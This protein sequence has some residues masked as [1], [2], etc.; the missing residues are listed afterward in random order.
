M[1]TV[2]TT[3][4]LPVERLRSIEPI[5]R[6]WDEL[7]DRTGASPFLRPGWFAAWLSA[8]G[9]GQQPV[10][11][12]VRRD[13]RLEAVLPLLVGRRVRCPTNS[14]TP[15]FDLV[16]G[17]EDAAQAIV[18]DVLGVRAPQLDLTY[19]DSEGMLL[20]AWRE[21]DAGR[22]MDFTVRTQMRSPYVPLEG[23]FETFRAGLSRNFR[24]ELTRHRKR[25]GEAGE[26]SFEFT[27][28]GDDLEA[29]LDVGFELESS[30]WK[31]EEGTA[32]ASRP[33]RVAFYREIAAWA[34][35]RGW[36]TL[37]F[38]RLDGVAIAFDFCIE[39]GGRVYVLKGGYDPA[40][41]KFSPAY[42]L[43]EET[44]ARA[45]ASGAETYELL[46]DDAPYKLRLTDAVR[47]RDHLQAFGRRPG[48]WVRMVGQR[49]VRERI[50]RR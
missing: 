5:A 17:D 34:R 18:Y 37:A 36:L 46:G 45:Y 15:V 48:G 33:D 3:T 2:T 26:L 39:Q 49:Y 24:K 4:M 30:G 32:I 19:L 8:F 10:V 25:L 1:A 9:G 44:I 38:A 20:R 16:A 22:R 12:T 42:L 41:K 14:H 11:L 13:G 40:W 6:E 29:A 31:A 23:D 35:E 47:E 28:G 50:K 21:L 27:D 43:M 7:A